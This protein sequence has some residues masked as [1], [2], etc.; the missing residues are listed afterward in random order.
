VR[1]SSTSVWKGTSRSSNSAS[2]IPGRKSIPQPIRKS[3]RPSSIRP[4]ATWS[5]TGAI[6]PGPARP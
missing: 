5:S 3:P 2:V 1:W 6:N 4:M